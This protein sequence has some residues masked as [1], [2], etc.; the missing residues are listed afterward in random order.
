MNK[1]NIS[2]KHNRLK[3]CCNKKDQISSLKNIDK[4]HRRT[5]KTKIPKFFGK[6]AILFLL[7]F[8]PLNYKT[9]EEHTLSGK[10]PD[11]PKIN[12]KSE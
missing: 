5:K 8:E 4:R 2:H 3:D 11:R 1:G 10:S 12:V 6:I 9:T 7:R